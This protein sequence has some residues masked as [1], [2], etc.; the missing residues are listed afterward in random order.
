MDTCTTASPSARDVDPD[1]G[2]PA[3]HDRASL[4]SWASRPN[5]AASDPASAP[6]PS[7]EEGGEG[8][9]EAS[10]DR[11]GK[12]SE[13][14]L[15]S[16]AA[17]SPARW[18]VAAWAW[19]AVCRD[20]CRLAACD[21]SSEHVLEIA[22]TMAWASASASVLAGWAPVTMAAVAGL[23]AAAAAAA[24]AVGVGVGPVQGL[25]RAARAQPLPPRRCAFALP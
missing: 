18:T 17:A 7:A 12:G 2:K 21:D 24:A 13:A 14:A 1:P 20:C 22:A 11:R 9:E 25:V 5:R 23:A 8:D 19:A 6:A 10:R 4:V 3:A 15:A 16:N